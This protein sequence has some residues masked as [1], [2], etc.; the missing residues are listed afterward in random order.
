MTDE[1]ART[2]ALNEALFRAVN[3]RIHEVSDDLGSVEDEPELQILCECG[4]LHCTE[5]LSIAASEYERIRSGAALFV[6][7]GGHTAP[8]V[9]VV[10]AD[11]GEY[12]VVRKRSGAPEELAEA[13]DPREPSSLS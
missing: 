10:V 6:V 5:Q 8:D 9:E 12:Q 11:A 4:D 13:T 1:R 2:I 7:A 3:E